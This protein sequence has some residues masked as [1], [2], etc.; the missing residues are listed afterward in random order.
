MKVREMVKRMGIPIEGATDE[1]L[2]AVI[3][4]QMDD[5][6]DKAP[7]TATHAATINLDGIRNNR[8]G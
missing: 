2:R 8:W 5:F 1:Q 6:L 3:Q 4:R 7:L